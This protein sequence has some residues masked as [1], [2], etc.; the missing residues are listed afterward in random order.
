MAARIALIGS[1]GY[2]DLARVRAYVRSLPA[3]TM[4][5]SGGACGAVGA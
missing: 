2:P 1:R 4:F 3:D 5:I